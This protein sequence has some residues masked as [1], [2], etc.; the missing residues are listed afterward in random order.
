MEPEQTPVAQ[1]GCEAHAAVAR[2]IAGNISRAVQVSAETLEHL[3]VALL[4]EGHV[5]VEDN[6]GVG[7]RSPAR[8]RAMVDCGFTAF[9]AGG[10]NCCPPTWWGA[11]VYDQR[12]QRFEF[13]PDRCSPTSSWWAGT[14]GLRPSR[15]PAC[16]SA[17]RSARDRRRPQ[18]TKLCGARLS[19]C[20]RRRNPNQYK[21][22]PTHCPT[23]MAPCLDQDLRSGTPTSGAEAGDAG[24]P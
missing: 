5:L 2:R 23:P 3:L 13:R 1:Q 24:R 17:C 12:E 16:W 4:A 8:W 11:D 15:S 21:R 10:S 20:S 18:P 6:P 19:S 22:G 14:T 9:V 7:R